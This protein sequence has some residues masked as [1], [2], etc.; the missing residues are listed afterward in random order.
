MANAPAHVV[1]AYL[2]H[3]NGRK[4]LAFTPGVK[5]AHDMADAFRD[6]GIVAEALDGGTPMEE[7]RDILRRLRDGEIKVVA[8][9]AVLSEGFDEPSVDC[10]I[11]AKPTKSKPLYIQMIGRGTRAY[12]GK[13]DCLILDVVGASS[14]HSIM[15]ADELFDLD[16]SLGSVR[17]AAEERERQDALAAERMFGDD[18]ELVASP[19]NLFQSRSLHW[20]QTR[21]GAW[22]LS[23]G[24]GFLRLTPTGPDSW[25]VDRSEDGQSDTI[26]REL[27]LDYAMG[28]AED[29]ARK[30]GSLV[31]I[32]PEAGWRGEPATEK[33]LNALL[34]WKVPV[35]PGMTNGAASNLLASII[36]DR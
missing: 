1:E 26:Q 22:V 25:S 12:P 27:P 8:N 20:Q 17:K 34:R 7:R 16:L 2:E 21:Q 23:L 9:C 13:A 5:L 15:T 28:V 35:M 24:Q 33:Q 10:I 3:A 14:R 30:Q 18:A 6:A 4:A 19:V 32:D 36:G 31:L 11:I 29:Y